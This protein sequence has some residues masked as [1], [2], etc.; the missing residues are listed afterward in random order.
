MF[1]GVALQNYAQKVAVV[2]AREISYPGY[3]NLAEGGDPVSIFGTNAIDWETNVKIE[4]KKATI[5][6]YRYLTTLGKGKILDDAQLKN[7]QEVA[8]SI[9]TENS[10][11]V[12]DKPIEIEIET[13][14]YFISQQV[15]ITITETLP[16]PGVF[17]W[18][19]ETS[20]LSATASATANDPDEYVRNTDLVFDFLDILGKKLGIKDG[21]SGAI[22]KVKSVIEDINKI[23]L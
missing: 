18:F 4:V 2:A 21:I 7:L 13:E 12:T 9:V 15:D 14:N 22:E 20:K 11:L 10:L 17:S 8:S 19:R 1:Q 16:T 6:P 3:M 23:G 5:Y